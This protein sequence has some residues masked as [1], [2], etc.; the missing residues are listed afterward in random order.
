MIFLTRRITGE[1]MRPINVFL[2]LGLCYLS[3]LAVM[4]EP[5]PTSPSPPSQPQPPTESIPIP[6]TTAPKRAHSAAV[7]TLLNQ[8]KEQFEQ[9][10]TE[11][12]AALLER[13]LRIEPRNSVLWHNLAGVRLKQQDWQRAANLAAKSNTLAGDNKWL[14]VRN[15]VITAIAC[16]GMSD[17]ECAQEAKQRSKALAAN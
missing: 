1:I 13:A 5:T 10:E 11:Q 7:E 8:A 14:R 4:A 9:N 17:K 3:P 12:A 16:E 6:E 2:F 15:W